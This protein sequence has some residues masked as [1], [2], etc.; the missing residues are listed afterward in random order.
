[1]D[2][3]TPE[4]YKMLLELGGQN[5]EEEAA[6]KA[7]LVQ[8]DQLR[9][10]GETPQGRQAGRLYIPPNPLEYLGALANQ[11]VARQKRDKATEMQKQGAQRQ[12]EQNRLMMQAILGQQQ[13][14][15]P[16]GGGG[17]QPPKQRSPFSLGGDY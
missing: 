17:F 1:M 6:I 11:N 2:A 10:M 8:A 15:Q 16:A 5:S 7:M 12:S 14:Q 4:Q 13:P 3:L 9:E